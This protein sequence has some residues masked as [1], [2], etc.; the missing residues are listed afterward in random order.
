MNVHGFFLVYFGLAAACIS[1]QFV[2]HLDALPEFTAKW[3]AGSLG[4]WIGS[5]SLGHWGFSADGVW[6]LPEF[7]GALIVAF[8]VASLWKARANAHGVAKAHL[9]GRP[10]AA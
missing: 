2:S 1:H 8:V 9:R 7:A 5:V 6:F 10:T 4:A 3:V